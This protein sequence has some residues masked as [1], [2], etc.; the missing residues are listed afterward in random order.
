MKILPCLLL[1]LTF[2]VFAFGQQNVG[3]NAQNFT[4]TSMT[5]ENN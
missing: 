4:G 5:N 2:S 1:I 3:E